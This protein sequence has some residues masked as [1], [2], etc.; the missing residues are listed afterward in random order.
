MHKEVNNNI[1][2]Y[3]YLLYMNCFPG[4]ISIEILL[5]MWVTAYTY[6]DCL[7]SKNQEARVGMYLAYFLAFNV[8]F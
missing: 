5:N 1:Y 6:A 8:C 3:Y 7:R 2:Y 4:R